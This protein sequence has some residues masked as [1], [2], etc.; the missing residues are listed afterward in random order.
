MRDSFI[1]KINNLVSIDL[2]SGNH[3]RV[4][5]DK[6]QDDKG[7]V[8]QMLAYM[9]KMQYPQLDITYN[10]ML[11]SKVYDGISYIFTHGHLPFVKK[12]ISKVLFDYG[13]Q[14]YYN[15]LVKGHLHSREV[16]KTYRRKQLDFEDY[17]VVELDE[18]DYRAITA[19]PIFTGNFFSESLGFT[20]SSGAAVIES[21]GRGKIN[22]FDYCL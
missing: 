8:A 11:I 19:P 22:Y 20:S 3:D 21:N 17:S 14:G 5:A 12:E 13:K 4:T 2:V 1:S 15:V 6:A 18:Q 7:E 10:P 9:F 16:K